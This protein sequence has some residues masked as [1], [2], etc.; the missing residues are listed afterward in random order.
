MHTVAQDNAEAI[1]QFI[2]DAK[3]QGY[4]FGSLD[5]LVLEYEKISP[6]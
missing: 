5:D 1:P 3:A 4:T 6:Y 2:K